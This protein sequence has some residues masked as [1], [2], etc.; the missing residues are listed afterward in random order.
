VRTGS[1]LLEVLTQ[2]DEGSAWLVEFNEFL[3]EFGNRSDSV[4]DVDEPSW[5]E[6]PT[7]AL[8]MIEAMLA[9]TSTEPRAHAGPPSTIPASVAASLT[10]VARRRFREAYGRLRR[11]NFAWWNE[12]HNFYIDLRAHLP[13]RRVGMAVG[14]RFL[15]SS[16]SGLMLFGNE[17]LALCRGD[18]DPASL[19]ALTESRALTHRVWS[20]RRS[21]L[22]T[23]IGSHDSPDPV[24]DQLF[25]LH[26]T[27]DQPTPTLA[28]NDLVHLRGIAVVSGQALGRAQVVRTMSDTADLGAG[29][30]MVCEGTTPSWLNAF[31][32]I[33]ACVCEFGG[34]LSHAAIASRET[35]TVCV[36]GVRGATSLIHDGDLLEVNGA[37]G[38]VKVIARN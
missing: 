19:R 11:A 25:G 16:P 9:P 5:R 13:V 26:R 36:V 4:I 22:P 20:T 23:R 12:E 14:R 6:D 7:L 33:A 3:V 18:A 15:G 38:E 21:E 30:V 37:T 32:H 29:D 17:L 24:V 27:D 35:N 34:P 8:A 1:D 28:S 10:P 2:T 31:S